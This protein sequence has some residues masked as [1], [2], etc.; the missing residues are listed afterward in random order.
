VE[1]DIDEILAAGSAAAEDCGGHPEPGLLP[2]MKEV[3]D[4]FGA[5][6]LIRPCAAIA[7]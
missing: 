5:G 4:R 7:G 2:A 3:G 1:A 6:E